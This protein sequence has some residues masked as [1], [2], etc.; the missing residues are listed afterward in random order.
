LIRKIADNRIGRVS[1]GLH[2]V[3]AAY[4]G[5]IHQMQE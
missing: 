4:Y 1:T 3:D 5:R 2:L